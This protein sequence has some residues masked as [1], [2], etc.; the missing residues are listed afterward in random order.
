M[1]LHDNLVIDRTGSHDYDSGLVTRLPT[2]TEYGIRLHTCTVCGATKNEYIAKLPAEKS[3]APSRTAVEIFKDIKKGDW[4]VKNGAIDYAYNNGFFKGVTDTTFE[5]DTSVTRGMFVTVLGRLHGVKEEKA[6]T[7]F[8]DVKK[9]AYYSGFVAWAAKA[10]VV[11]GATPTAFEP[12]KS[13][14]RE[15]ICAMMYRYCD[16]ADIKLQNLQK[17]VTFGDAREISSYAKKAVDACQRGAI[18][19]GKGGGKFDPQGN[20]TRA[21]VATI[22][23]NFCKNY[24]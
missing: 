5:P 22:L 2:Q 9:S 17:A 19:S 14:T 23:M 7:Q 21:E 8:A 1:V 16:Y 20:A 15:Q 4:F 3:L 12:E 11:T 10:G 13:V 6:K 18:V 24:K